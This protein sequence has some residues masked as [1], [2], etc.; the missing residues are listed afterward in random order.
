M[1]NRR[2]L[3]RVNAAGRRP[4]HSAAPQ[5]AELRIESLGARGDGIGQAG[6]RPVY[7][8]LTVP[9]DCVRVSL[10]ER[11]GEGVAAEVLDLI[12][13]SPQRQVPPCRHFG[14]CGGCA[15]QHLAPEAYQAWKRGL[16]ADALAHRGIRD[17]EVLAPVQV[18]PGTRRRVT[19]GA[20]RRGGGVQLGFSTRASHRIVDLQECVVALPGIVALFSPLRVALAAVLR[21]GERAEA[22]L[23]MTDSGADLLLVGQREPDRIAREALASFAEAADLARLSWSAP[24]GSPEPMAWRRPAFVSFGGVTVEPPPGAFLQPTGAGEAALVRAARDALAGQKRVVDLYAGC[25]TFS[26]PL[27]VSGAA[28][29]S[30]EGQA[31]S[32]AAI[33]AAAGGA[34]LGGRLV[35]ETRDLDERPLEPQ[36]LA[37]FS[38]A[39]FDPPRAGARAQVEMLARSTLDTIVAVSCNPATFARD[40]RIL[41]DAGFR[42]SPVTPVDQ[43]LW[44]SHLELVA[45][46][47]R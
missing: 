44:S 10:R 43:F 19:L 38:A 34:G 3:R 40:A 39:L 17:A 7:V 46:F 2:N 22:M 21:D 36:E 13:P 8:P 4:V 18:P 9:G 26:F 24:G 41:V 42:M 15:A 23:T 37:R 20:A 31:A 16:V 6:G 35:A 5:T 30:V 47:A 12:E 27:A 14:T 1:M 29:R 25:G 32:V 45:R 11:R 33:G 28:V